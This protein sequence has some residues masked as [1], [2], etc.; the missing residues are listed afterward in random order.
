M[1]RPSVRGPRGPRGTL[2]RLGSRLD[3]VERPPPARAPVA[4]ESVEPWPPDGP[5]HG[6][7]IGHEGRGP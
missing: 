5:V 7:A 6:T 4:L 2:R 3:L 1:S